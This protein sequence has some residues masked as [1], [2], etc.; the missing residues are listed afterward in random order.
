[1]LEAAVVGV[2]DERWG[3]AIKAVVVLK[4]GRAASREELMAHCRERLARYKCPRSVDFIG[5]LPRT[6]SGKISKKE[7][8]EPYWTGHQ[9]R[10]G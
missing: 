5:A 8:R 10:V 6:G 7:I 9:T 2:P 3:E 4:E 1:V